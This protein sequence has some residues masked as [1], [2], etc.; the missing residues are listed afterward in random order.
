MDNN[1]F[2]DI[3]DDYKGK[4]E[5]TFSK[6]VNVKHDTPE[7]FNGYQ[8][9][10]DI[11]DKVKDQEIFK[12]M[13][14]GRNSVPVLKYNYPD[15]SLYAVVFYNFVEPLTDD[16]LAEVSTITNKQLEGNVIKHSIG[17]EEYTIK[18]GAKTKQYIK[19]VNLEAPKDFMF[20]EDIFE[21]QKDGLA[22][23]EFL[24]HQLSFDRL[25]RLC[26]KIGYEVTEDMIT[27]VMLPVHRR[28]DTGATL[29][30]EEVKRQFDMYKL[31]QNYIRGFE[32][33]SNEYALGVAMAHDIKFNDYVLRVAKRQEGGKEPDADNFTAEFNRAIKRINKKQYLD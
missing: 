23:Q 25:K 3:E 12:N 13:I 10:F 2:N 26:K 20:I 33:D 7:L 4:T 19:Q 1:M 6:K 15:E 9:D 24:N 18:L 8:A 32:E 27:G 28:N 5:V 14:P 16:E 30:H 29:V 21:D 22:Y 17:K 31:A 11:V